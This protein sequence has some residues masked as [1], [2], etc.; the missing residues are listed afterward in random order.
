MNFRYKLPIRNF[1]CK[2]FLSFYGASSH[3][4]DGTVFSRRGGSFDCVHLF[5]FSFITCAFSA[6]SKMA[7]PKLPSQRFAPV[8]SSKRFT[9]LAFVCKSVVRFEFIF[10]H[11][12]SKESS[13][14]LP[15]GH[16][17]LSQLRLLKK[18]SF[19]CR[20]ALAPLSKIR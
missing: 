18:L 6:T 2:Y 4:L 11:G 5:I 3:F 9:V 1:I 14:T 15:Q 13:S 10:V 19:P 12:V 7:V 20:A 17:P 8:F 16:T